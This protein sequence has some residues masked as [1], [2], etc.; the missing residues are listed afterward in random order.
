MGLIEE[1]NVLTPTLWIGAPPCLHCCGPEALRKRSTPFQ[2]EVSKAQNLPGQF[3]KNPSFPPPVS[4]CPPGRF[5]F[6]IHPCKGFPKGLHVP[7]CKAVTLSSSCHPLVWVAVA[8]W[9]A[10]GR[11]SGFTYNHTQPTAFSPQPSSSSKLWM[12]GASREA[13]LQ[14]VASAPL[15]NPPLK[16]FGHQIWDE[17]L[18]AV[19]LIT[20]S[21]NK[22]LLTCTQA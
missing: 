18:S 8:G 20:I 10:G 17:I 13:Q 19:A 9:G 6:C 1:L 3:N 16:L 22:Y 7:V 21:L 2:T 15:Y 5:S 11:E 14:E 4:P 12:G